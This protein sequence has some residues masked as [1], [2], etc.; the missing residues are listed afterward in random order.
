V[1]S[2]YRTLRTAGIAALSISLAFVAI[3]LP[4]GLREFTEAG[5]EGRKFIQYYCFFLPSLWVIY[6]LLV[7][8]S[9]NKRRI[10]RIW[11]WALAGLISSYASSVISIN[12]IEL[13]RVDGW[14]QLLR[15]LHRSGYWVG[16]IAYPLVSLSWFVGV[17]SGGLGYCINRWV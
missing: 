11:F 17:V 4:R 10:D 7:L 15:E 14:P 3:V 6:L 2:E 5:L 1:P 16:L 8:A 9:R 12:L 13:L